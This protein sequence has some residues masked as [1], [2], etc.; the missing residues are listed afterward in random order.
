MSRAGIDWASEQIKLVRQIH[1]MGVRGVSGIFTWD[2]TA[3][4]SPYQ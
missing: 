2:L 4:H 3:L 1:V